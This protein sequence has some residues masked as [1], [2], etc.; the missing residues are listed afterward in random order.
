MEYP[1]ESSLGRLRRRIDGNALTPS[2]HNEVGLVSG[3]GD[4]L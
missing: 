4:L 2:L 1:I 3:G